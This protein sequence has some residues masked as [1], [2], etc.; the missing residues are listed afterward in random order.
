MKYFELTRLYKTDRQFRGKFCVD[1]DRVLQNSMSLLF[2]WASFVYGK[3]RPYNAK[4]R[5][6]IGLQTKMYV[7]N[8]DC[9]ILHTLHTMCINKSYVTV[10]TDNI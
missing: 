3:H 8:V 9:H 4:L 1:K 10:T 5:M 2:L 6:L 7:L